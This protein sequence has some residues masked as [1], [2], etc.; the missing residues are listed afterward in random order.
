[1]GGLIGKAAGSTAKGAILGAVVGGAA[2]A[3]IGHRMDEQAKELENRLPNA[4]VERVGEGIQVTFD[5]GILFDV[6]SDVLRAASQSNLTALAKSIADYPGTA[7]LVVGHTD[8]TGTD[9]HNQTLSER[10]ADSA[11]AFLLQQGVASDRVT[12]TGKGE[13]EPIS[14]NDTAEGRQQN[15]RV[16]VAI[17]ADEAFQK[18][19]IAQYGRGGS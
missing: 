10:R 14:T 8:N 11:R 7:I 15:R 5:S 6:D 9:A 19:M 3:V 4:T 18:K 2:G 12:A 1:V 16:E 13:S 17:F